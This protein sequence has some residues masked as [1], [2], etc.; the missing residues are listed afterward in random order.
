VPPAGRARAIG[1]WSA[2]GALARRLGPVIGGSLVQL[3]WRWVF[4]INLPVGVV[5]VLLATRVVPESRD[6]ARPWP[7]GPAR[8]RAAGAAV[9][10]I[11]LAL[12]KA[13]DWGWGR[14]GS[15]G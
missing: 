9:G 10:L 3:S 8:R 2:L 12:V 15:A 1:T 11:A 6:G 13:P 14:L 5:A 7:A 4:W